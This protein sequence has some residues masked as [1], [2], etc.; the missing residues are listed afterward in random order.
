MGPCGVENGGRKGGRR[1]KDE[2]KVFLPNEATR[3]GN[4]RRVVRENKTERG[5]HCKQDWIM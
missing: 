5:G 1:A 4:E 3:P 2:P